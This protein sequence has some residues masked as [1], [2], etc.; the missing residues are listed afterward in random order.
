MDKTASNG[1]D[2]DVQIVI[3]SILKVDENNQQKAHCME[4]MDA[5]LEEIQTKKAECSKNNIEFF[6]VWDDDIKTS[7]ITYYRRF[8]S[9]LDTIFKKADIKLYE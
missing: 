8:V 4:G 9:I 5:T 7:E 1:L 3:D 6:D 2:A